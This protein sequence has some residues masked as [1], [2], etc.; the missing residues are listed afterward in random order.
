MLYFS[1]IL[2]LVLV[3][4]KFSFSSM[5][6]ILIYNKKDWDCNDDI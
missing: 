2:I 1:F 4:V 3:L 5:A 6:F